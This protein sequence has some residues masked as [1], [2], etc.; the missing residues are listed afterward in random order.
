[1]R[2]LDRIATVVGFRVIP[3]TVLVLLTYVTIFTLVIVTDWLPEPP[4]TQNG[5][6]LK[7]AY[8]D[9]R[10]VS[11]R[12]PPQLGWIL[13][14][15]FRSQ[16]THIRTTPTTTTQYTL[17][18]SRDSARW[19]LRLLMFIYPM[20]R[21]QMAHGHP[22]DTVSTLRAPISLLRLMARVRTVMTECCSQHIM[23][24]CPLHQARPMMAWVL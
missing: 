2:I 9:L 23:I 1:M 13:K 12:F 11:A 20:I 10:H 4:K 18:Y 8:T 21:L 22:P 17:I 3:T 15:H 5:L 24:R 14:C 19:Q 16:H 7:Q 6:D